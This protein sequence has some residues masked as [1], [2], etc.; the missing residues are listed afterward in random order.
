MTKS[1]LV[2]L[3]IT[4]ATTLGVWLLGQAVPP[5]YSIFAQVVGGAVL[6]LVMLTI[7]FLWLRRPQARSEPP[8]LRS[9]AA[10]IIDSPSSHA[11]NLNL[12][13][14]DQG[15]IVRGSAGTTIDGA[16]I[17]AKGVALHVSGDSPSNI[18]NSVI[19]GEVRAGDFPDDE[20]K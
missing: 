3:T 8:A 5:D 1:T 10:Q 6:F 16:Y 18:K 13:G 2:V 14:H 15:L 12:S 11:R 9:T 4:I 7:A 19:W 20:P 17:S